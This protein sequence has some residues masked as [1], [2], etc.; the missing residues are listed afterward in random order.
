MSYYFARDIYKEP[1][2]SFDEELE[3]RNSQF[4]LAVKPIF[5][6]NAVEKLHP[7]ANCL[8][9]PKMVII[10]SPNGIIMVH[11]DWLECSVPAIHEEGPLYVGLPGTPKEGQVFRNWNDK[12]PI[13]QIPPERLPQ[14]C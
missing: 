4:M 8:P 7:E 3:R 12:F 5:F 9:D 6:K 10:R 1:M 14:V 2:N 13:A 11:W